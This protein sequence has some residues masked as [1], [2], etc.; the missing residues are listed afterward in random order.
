MGETTLHIQPYNILCCYAHST[1][2]LFSNDSS[3][4]WL[5]FSNFT[6]ILRMVV[7][8]SI[9]NLPCLT[10]RVRTGAWNPW[11]Y[12]KTKV[13]K[14]RTW[15]YLNSNKGAWKPLKTSFICLNNK[16]ENKTEQKSKKET[17]NKRQT[18]KYLHPQN[19]WH[20]TSIIF[21]TRYRHFHLKKG[22]VKQGFIYEMLRKRC[23]KTNF[24]PGKSLKSPWFFST[25][26]CMNPVYSFISV[27][28]CI[29]RGL[30][31]L[32]WPGPILLM[33]L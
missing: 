22:K 20:W 6:R 31:A 15:K 3:F 14:S 11:K 16:C 13:A 2:S 23:L 8:E 12:L 17:Q 18:Q 26:K 7:W 32:L 21:L 9:Y 28:V 27:S 33:S 10:Y 29:D 30:S 4:S 19:H 5:F 1:A 24:S 25:K